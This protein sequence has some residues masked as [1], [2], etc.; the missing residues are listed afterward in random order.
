M[1]LIAVNGSPRKKWNTARLL[2]KV[3]DGAKAAGMGAKLVHLYDFDFKGCISCFGCKRIGGKSYGRCAMRDG[4]T[5]LLDEIHG[6]DALALGSPVYF[7][8]ET[9]ET[10]SFM[11]RVAFQYLRYADPPGTLFP[12]R[13]RTALVYTMNVNEEQAG[14]MGLTARTD[15]SRWFTERVFGSC[16]VLNSYDTLQF[17][18][19]DAYENSRFDPKAKMRRHEEVFPKDM[20]QA[21]E[22]G[23]RMALPLPETAERAGGD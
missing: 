18:D 6:A 8:A 17:S 15:M 3:V 5:P 4:L 10:R 23:Q 7:M 22:L 1:K 14:A 9:G 20:E 19:Y 2:E 12:R 16:E 21:F 13:I 11:E